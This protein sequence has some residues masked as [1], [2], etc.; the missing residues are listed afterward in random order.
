MKLEIS[1][2]GVTRNSDNQM[3]LRVVELEYL[4]DTGLPTASGRYHETEHD[5]ILENIS[6]LKI[7]DLSI[8]FSLALQPQFGPWPTS[9][10]LSV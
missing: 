1:T 8:F 3:R 10:K 6:L 9:I 7:D 5:L 4:T 2:A